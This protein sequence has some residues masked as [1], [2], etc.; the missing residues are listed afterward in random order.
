MRERPPVSAQ[1][2]I[3]LE[4]HPPSIFT[5]RLTA[6]CGVWCI[7]FSCRAKGEVWCMC[8]FGFVGLGGEGFVVL[9]QGFCNLQLQFSQL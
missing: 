4:C 6:K 7:M 5:Y 3:S 1:Y 9:R 2:L 8:L